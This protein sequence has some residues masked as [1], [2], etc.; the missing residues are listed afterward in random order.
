VQELATSGSLRNGRPPCYK[1]LSPWWLRRT[2]SQFPAQDQKNS[3]KS[4]RLAPIVE[5]PDGSLELPPDPKRVRA[6]KLISAA[7]VTL[8]IVTWLVV[9][10]VS[11][12]LFD[13]SW[14]AR[15][16]LLAVALVFFGGTEWLLWAALK[17]PVLKADA[18]EVVCAS[19]LSRQRMP[20][21]DLALI[22]RGQVIRK[23]G[24]TRGLWDKSY[25][26]AAADG[27]VGMSCGSLLF[28]PDGMMQFA[29]RLQVPIRGDFGAQVKDRVDP[30]M[31]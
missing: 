9:A 3:V 17:P 12:A 11:V 22:F 28:T 30:T 14:P 2:R 13:I 27:K 5:L 8:A 1:T 31:S 20:R 23:G 21:S 16:L 7:S 19:P 6:V 15:L 26:F 25:I 10:W 18:M 24:R 4:L 29:Q